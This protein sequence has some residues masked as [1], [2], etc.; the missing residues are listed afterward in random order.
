MLYILIVQVSSKTELWVSII[1]LLGRWSLNGH[2]MV[3]KI[4]ICKFTGWVSQHNRLTQKM[5]LKR[6]S[7]CE[8]GKDSDLHI[9]F[10]ALQGDRAYQVHMIVLFERWSLKVFVDGNG[11]DA[12]SACSL[13]RSPSRQRSLTLYDS[14]TQKMVLR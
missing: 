1:V 14:F 13:F 7:I 12:C 2:S 3:G 11:E 4:Q 8:T 10:S 5:F 9:H 6:L